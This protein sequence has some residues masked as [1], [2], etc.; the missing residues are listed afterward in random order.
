MFYFG[1]NPV[2]KCTRS[3]PQCNVN[4][5][6]VTSRRILVSP[7]AAPSIITQ[8]PH[9]L[10]VQ[11]ARRLGQKRCRVSFRNSSK[12]QACLFRAMP[13]C[14]NSISIK[15]GVFVAGRQLGSILRMC[16]AKETKMAAGYK[17]DEYN[18][19]YFYSSRCEPHCIE[20]V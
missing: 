15:R 2:E 13:Y 5:G 8:V 10:N 4:R 19:I 6:K 18:R 14:T 9:S 20:E 7:P 1:E 12:A 17:Y 3:F 11:T 16:S